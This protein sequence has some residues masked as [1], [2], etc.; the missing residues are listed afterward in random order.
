ML[1]DYRG[2]GDGE[3]ITDALMLSLAVLDINPDV[4]SSN[5]RR[6]FTKTANVNR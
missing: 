5:S 3:K 4:W 6:S 2:V 1:W